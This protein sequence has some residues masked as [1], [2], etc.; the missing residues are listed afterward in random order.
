M[1]WNNSGYPDEDNCRR[2]EC[3][4]E[5]IPGTSSK[6]TEAHDEGLALLV[7]PGTTFLWEINWFMKSI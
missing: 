7:K 2:N 5:P 6:L 4:F 1:W 3:A